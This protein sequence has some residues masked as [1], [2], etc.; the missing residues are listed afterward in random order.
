MSSED[1]VSSGDGWSNAQIRNTSP[2]QAITHRAD[3]TARRAEIHRGFQKMSDEPHAPRRPVLSQRGR[4]RPAGRVT[5]RREGAEKGS[6]GVAPGPPSRRASPER[7]CRITGSKKRAMDP[8]PSGDRCRPAGPASSG[9]TRHVETPAAGSGGAERGCD[10]PWV[11]EQAC[12]SPRTTKQS[13]AICVTSVPY[14][15]PRRA[16]WSR[17]TFRFRSTM[18]KIDPLPREE[19]KEHYKNSGVRC[20]SKSAAAP[21]AGARR[22]GHRPQRH[23][24]RGPCAR[25]RVRS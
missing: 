20:Q 21:C 13:K 16:A 9:G 4:H 11:I 1:R 17:A 15:P 2:D 8:M 10:R 6:S 24:D 23:A 3:G 25:P 18:S 5:R 22:H 14:A 7:D 12:L 19:R